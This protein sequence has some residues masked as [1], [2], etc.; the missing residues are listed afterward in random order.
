MHPTDNFVDKPVDTAGLARNECRTIFLSV[1][2]QQYKTI[3]RIKNLSLKQKTHRYDDGF[4][5]AVIFYL[6]YIFGN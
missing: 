6:L 3:Q 4:F 2:F 5:S 1:P